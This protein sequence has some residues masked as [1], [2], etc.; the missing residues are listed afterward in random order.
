ML[1]TFFTQRALKCKLGTKRTPQGHSKDT[2]R[3]LQGNS[4][5]TWVLEEHLGS[6]ALEH[7]RHSG[8][9]ALEEHLSTWVLRQNT[10]Y[11]NIGFVWKISCHCIDCV[12]IYPIHIVIIYNS[13]NSYSQ[14]V[15]F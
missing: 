6:L 4:K 15:Q 10:E 11:R 1:Q 14:T 8:T 13:Y 12:S 9:L 7:L 3:S 2:L 5:G